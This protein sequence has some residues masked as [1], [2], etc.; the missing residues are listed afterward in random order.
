M[1]FQRLALAAAFL[2]PL[3]AQAE[4][5]TLR[6]AYDRMMSNEIEFQIL[7]LEAGV[8]EEYVQQARAALR[9]RVTL[10]LEANHVGQD[11]TSSDNTSYARGSSDYWTGN[12]ALNVIQPLYDAARFR[13][14]SVA[15]AQQ[16]LNTIK[17]ERA[18]NDLIL[19]MTE[20]FLDVG[21][22]QFMLKRSDQLI[23]ARQQYARLLDEQSQAGRV[24]MSASLRAEGELLSALADRTSADMDLNQALFEFSRFAGGNV[25]GV[26]LADNRLGLANS[27]SLRSTLKASRLAELNPAIQIAR[28]ELAVAQRQKEAVK[29]GRLPV[30]NLQAGL[31]YDYTEGSLFG[32]GSTVRS[33][34][35]GIAMNVPIYQGGSQESREREEA[36]RLRIA[37]QRLELAN[38]VAKSQYDSLVTA[39][40]RISGRVAALIK[41]RSAALEAV[42]VARSEQDA[43]R[44][45]ADVALERSLSANLLETEIQAAR[46]QQLR[47]QLRLYAL[48]GALDVNSLSKQ[49]NG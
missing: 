15:K 41:Q 19:E 40:G 39:E 17:A 35:I 28:A 24:D 44:V 16:E 3:S 25:T 6:T 21:A 11:I 30:V 32:G 34:Q 37:E 9:P 49:L 26:S 4:Q 46:L 1:L 23:A 45:G 10:N 43:G 18:R 42:S 13:Q 48:F 22:A 36:L 29:G 7:M 38:R 27:K 14:V 20:R 31:E 12:V 2:I 47:V 5:I 33:D 8:A